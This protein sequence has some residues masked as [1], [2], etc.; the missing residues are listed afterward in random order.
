MTLA[1]AFDTLRKFHKRAP[2]L[3]FNGNTFATIGRELNSDEEGNEHQVWFQQETDTY[4]KVPWSDFFGLLVLY[5]Q[6]T[7]LDYVIKACR[8]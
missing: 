2:F 5:R 7:L 8:V 6:G 3:F 4:L 1:A